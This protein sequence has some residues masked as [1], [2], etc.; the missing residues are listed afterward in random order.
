[1]QIKSL[2]LKSYRSWAVDDTPK[3][4]IALQ[5]LK[6]IRLYEQLRQDGCSQIM[7]LKAIEIS[8]PTY[9]RWKKAY[10]EGGLKAQLETANVVFKKQLITSKAPVYIERSGSTIEAQ[11]MSYEGIKKL[12]TFFGPVKVKLI[13]SPEK[14]K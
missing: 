10:R 11:G 4:P 8:K 6:K 3:C 5:R 2:R 7:A 1:M 12:M 9:Y 14:A 13:K